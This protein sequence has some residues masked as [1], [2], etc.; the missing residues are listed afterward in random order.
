[1][2]RYS[3]T[4]ARALPKLG[5]CSRNEAFDLI[6]SARVK[7]NGRSITDPAKNLSPGDRITIDGKS[8]AKEERRYIIF[9]KPAGC[10]TTRKDERRR[11]TV[12]DVLG[13]VGGRVF[14]VGRLDKETEGL[15][16]FTNDTAF[17]DH[18]TDPSNKIPRIYI[19]TVDGLLSEADMA[20]ALGGVDIGRG[21]R[22]HPT[23]ARILKRG[24]RKTVVE[25]TLVEGKNREVRR[26]CEALGAPVTK[27]VR[28]SFGPFR[29]EGLAS[30]EWREL[31][32][33]VCEK[34]ARLRQL[35]EDNGRLRRAHPPK[36]QVVR[37]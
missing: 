32:A 34:M 5:L 33:K 12:Y 9:N 11:Q 8:V 23:N 4:L 10:V 29:L 37:R 7:V 2:K 14:A 19:A 17:G 15:L 21:E 26:L 13:D 24:E 27:L 35:V 28:T 22:S 18:L 1:V 31:D 25:I 16:L 20:K 36:H 3:R 6:R 30:G